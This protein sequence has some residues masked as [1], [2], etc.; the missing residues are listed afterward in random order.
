MKPFANLGMSTLTIRTT[1][2]TD[3]QSFDAVGLP[4]FQFIQDPLEY[5]LAHAPHEPG[6][7]RA[8]DPGG[9]DAERDRRS[10]R[11]PITPRTATQPLPRKPLPKPQPATT[12][13]Q[14]PATTPP[15]TASGS[16]QR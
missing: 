15:P 12:P 4:G 9:P 2:G 14:R 16:A 6:R 3:H 1:G 7:L 10:R 8:R 11:S 13:G 5:S